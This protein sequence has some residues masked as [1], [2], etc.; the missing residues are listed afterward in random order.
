MSGAP[1]L[2]T[3][4]SQKVVV[5]V[6]DLAVSNNS[7]VTMSTFALG[8]CVGIIVYDSQIKAGGLIHLMLPDS[9]LSPDKA[10]AQPAMF[11]DT[12]IPLLMNSMKSLQAQR[13]R[14]K[15][16]V[17]GGASVISGS[18]M[19][20]IGE[21]NIAAVKQFVNAYSIKVVKADI[22]GV[23]NR[24]VH[25]NIGTGEVHLKTPVGASTFSLA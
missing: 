21:R 12:G 1:S 22:G 6:G 7:N 19:F 3:F 8:S 25:L 11:A 18:D 17:A 13:S 9:K 5:G 14:L 23:N 24:T 4:F 15:A 10:I 20:K 2:P 16:F